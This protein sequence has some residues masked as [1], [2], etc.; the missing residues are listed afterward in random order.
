VELFQDFLGHDAEIVIEHVNEIPVLSSGK[1]KK[2]M[3]NYIKE[4]A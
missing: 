2:V 4:K 3:S 1:R